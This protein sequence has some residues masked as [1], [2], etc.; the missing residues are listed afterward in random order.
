MGSVCECVQ[1]SKALSCAPRGRAMPKEQMMLFWHV[2]FKRKLDGFG[3]V[4]KIII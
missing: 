1:E 3:G 4:S 2:N